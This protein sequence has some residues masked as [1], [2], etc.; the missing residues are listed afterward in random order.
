MKLVNI[1]SAK[2]HLSSL[3]KQVED[4]ND[5]VIIERAGKP[6]AKIIKYNPHQKINR[7]GQ[8]KEQIIISED[9]DEWPEDLAI[10]LGLQD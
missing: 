3:L 1:T 5:E 6:I 4:K 2:A 8:F 10:K 9:F 7:I